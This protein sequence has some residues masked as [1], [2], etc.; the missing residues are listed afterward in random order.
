MLTSCSDQKIVKPDTPVNTG[1]VMESFLKAG[2]YED[3]NELF[4]DERKNS[5][6]IKQFNELRKL[7]T[8]GTGYELYELLTF[9]N[10]KMILIRLVP[11]KINGEYKIEDVKEVSKEIKSLLQ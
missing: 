1:I 7:T 8:A 6:S 3:F 10:E 4:T 2:N 5:V 11:D 9:S